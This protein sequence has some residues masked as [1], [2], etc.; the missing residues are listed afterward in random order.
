MEEVGS[1]D[2]EV[3][4]IYSCSGETGQETQCQMLK[5]WGVK[6]RKSPDHHDNDT[7]LCEE[8]EKME[9]DNCEQ[10]SGPTN[11]IESLTAQ[12]SLK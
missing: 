5:F 3:V 10:V 12:V 9:V 7:H 6:K 1:F 8:N 4:I 2:F 11:G